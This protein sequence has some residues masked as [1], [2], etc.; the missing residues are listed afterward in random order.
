[1]ARWFLANSTHLVDLA[2]LLAG[3]PQ[4]LTADVAGTLPLA[5]HGRGLRRIGPHGTRCALQL[6]RGLAV[7]RAV[8][9]RRVHRE[10]PARPAPARDSAQQVRRVLTI[11]PVAI[12]DTLDTQYKAG[13]YRQTAAFLTSERGALCSLAEHHRRLGVYC[14]MAGYPD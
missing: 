8:G 9:R 3:A 5:S 14:R 7:G 12:D 4:R 11:E 1:L 2:F 13:L 10:A 6:P